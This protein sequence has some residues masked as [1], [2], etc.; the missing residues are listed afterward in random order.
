MQVRGQ[1]KEQWHDGLSKEPQPHT[2]LYTSS[3]PWWDPSPSVWKGPGHVWLVC[4]SSSSSILEKNSIFPML[5]VLIWEW[6]QEAQPLLA[7]T[8]TPSMSWCR[9][10]GSQA[11]EQAI[12]G[13]HLFVPTGLVHMVDTWVSQSLGCCSYPILYTAIESLIL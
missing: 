10:G 6:K 7:H 5:I 8:P 12:F 3:F 13:H 9:G 4:S 2:R 1:P 11:L